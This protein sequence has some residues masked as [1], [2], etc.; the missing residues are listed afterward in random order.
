M[1]GKLLSWLSTSYLSPGDSSD[2]RYQHRDE[3]RPHP[4]GKSLAQSVE[5]RHPTGDVAATV[6]GNEQHDQQR[7]PAD[8]AYGP[9]RVR[10]RSGLVGGVADTGAGRYPDGRADG[11]NQRRKQYRG[12][13][14]GQPAEEGRSGLYPP[15]LGLLATGSLLAVLRL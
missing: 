3:D 8:D 11:G 13:G 14:C 9:G 15:V 7:D 5:P 1:R 4:H 2:Q 10:S 6:V 12:S